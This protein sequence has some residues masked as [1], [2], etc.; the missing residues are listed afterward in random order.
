MEAARTLY[1]TIWPTRLEQFPPKL[2]GRSLLEETKEAADREWFHELRHDAESVFWLLL[3]WA[4]HVCPANGEEAEAQI[5]DDFWAALVAPTE[6]GR[7]GR[8][9]LLTEMIDDEGWL[10]SAYKPLEGLLKSM[11]LHLRADL[12]W[13]TD[14]NE[15]FKEMRDP[16]FMHEAFQ[17][18]IFN[19]LVTNK[20]N[21]FMHQARAATNRVVADGA[22]TTSSETDFEVVQSRSSGGNLSSPHVAGSTPPAQT[23]HCEDP[24]EDDTQPVSN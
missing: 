9:K 10:H 4:V 6:S 18:H 19:F 15:N 21:P 13:V 2:A 12:H 24:E 8:K 1:E 22:W 14:K 7:D 17:R 23:P 16:E 3:W 20:E 5:W 11:A